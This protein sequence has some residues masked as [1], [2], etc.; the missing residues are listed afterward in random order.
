MSR[1]VFLDERCKGCLLCT[2]VCPKGI[3]VQ[4]SRFN[5]QGYKVAEV[6]ADAMKDCTG[7]ASCALI[8]PDVAIRVIKSRKAKKAGKE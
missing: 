5:R 3:I 6:P 4:S 1:V 2:T 8:C 7:C